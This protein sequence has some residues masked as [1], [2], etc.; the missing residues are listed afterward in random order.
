M[1][2]QAEGIATDSKTIDVQEL[3]IVPDADD[4]TIVM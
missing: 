1:F 3:T 4:D 2:I